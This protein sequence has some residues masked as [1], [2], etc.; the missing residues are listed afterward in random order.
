MRN[1]FD[2]GGGGVLGDERAKEDWRECV[3]WEMKKKP[4]AEEKKMSPEEKI[5]FY[6]GAPIPGD[7]P[8]SFSKR[9][10]KHMKEIGVLK[11]DGTSNV[12][13][14]LAKRA[15]VSEGEEGG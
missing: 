11:E 15:R 14:F 12:E 5:N 9:V 1:G 2:G 4:A 6:L 3:Q 13:E 7:T 8:E 10:V